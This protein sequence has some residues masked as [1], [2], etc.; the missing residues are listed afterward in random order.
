VATD[1]P[2]RD[3][4]NEQIRGGDHKNAQIL[5]MAGQNAKSKY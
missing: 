2:K 5:D 4:V 3:V 1:A